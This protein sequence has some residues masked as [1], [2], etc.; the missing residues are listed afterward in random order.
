[1][2]KKIILLFLMLSINCV[3][4]SP[5]ENILLVKDAHVDYNNSVLAPKYT[6]ALD[7]LGLNYTNCTVPDGTDNGPAYDGTGDCDEDIGGMKNYDIVIWFTGK[8]YSD[9]Y[10]TLTDTDRDNLKYFLDNGGKLFL[11]GENIGYDY[12]YH[13]EDG[14]NITAE[15]FFHNYLHSHYCKRT[16][17]LS[18]EG[19]YRDPITTGYTSMTPLNI[20]GGAGVNSDPD[21]VFQNISNYIIDYTGIKKDLRYYIALVK[22][23]SIGSYNSLVYQKFK[24]DKAIVNCLESLGWEDDFS[25]DRDND[26]NWDKDGT[27]WINGLGSVRADTGGPNG[28]KVA[29]FGFGFEGIN[30]SD[31]RI[32]VMNRT[33][34]YLAGPKTEGTKFYARNLD[35]TNWED[36]NITCDPSD[37]YCLREMNP[38]VNATCFNPQLFGNITGAEFFVN[39]TGEGNGTGMNA[40]D[41]FNSSTEIVNGSINVSDLNESTYFVNVHCKDSDNYWGKFDNYSFEVDNTTPST[42]NI[43]LEDGNKYTNKEKP[44]IE[45]SVN[46]SKYQPDFV[47]FSC[48]NQN[49][50]DWISYQQTYS[51]FNITDSNF[52]CNSTDGNRTIYAQ[53]RDIAGNYLDYSSDW[54]ILDRNSS[55]I[56][57]ISPKADWLNSTNVT[58]VFNFTDKFSPEANCS[59]YLDRTL[60]QTNSSVSNNT[61]TNFSASNLSEGSHTW[62]I[63]CEDL[64]GN[65]NSSGRDFSI[66]LSSPNTTDNS[67]VSEPWYGKNQIVEL[68]CSDPNLADG[69]SGSACNS[70]YY[71]IANKSNNCSSFSKGDLVNITC[72]EG[73]IC[74]K[75]ISYYSL[76]KAGNNETVKNS[77]FIRIDKKPP[78]VIINSP[79]SEYVKGD[80]LVNTTITDNQTIDK[81]Y[82]N[83]SNSTWSD[84]SNLSLS[85]SGSY[86][87]GTLDT[88]SISDGEYNLTIYAND[89]F[90]NPNNTE[91]VNITIDNTPPT[92]NATAVKE[93]GTD[94]TFDTWTNSSYVNV[95]L[96]C[97]DNGIGCNITSYCVDTAGTCS[98]NETYTNPIEIGCNKGEVCKNYI[99]YRSNDS[100]GNLEG[101]ET[102]NQIKIDKKAPEILIDSPEENETKSGIISLETTITEDVGV[103]ESWYKIVNRTNKSQVFD[104]GNL[105]GDFDTTWNST[106]DISEREIVTFLVSANDTLGNIRYNVS[107]NFTVD[108]SLPSVVIYYPKKIYLNE[109]FNLNLTAVATSDNNLSFV[110]YNITNSTGDLIKNNTN[111]SVNQVE[112]SFTDLINISN[113]LDGKYNISFY[114]NQTNGNEGTDLNW[115]SVDRVAPNTTDST[116]S[117]WNSTWFKQNKF[118]NLTCLDPNLSDGSC[119][120]SCDKTL[121]CINDSNGSCTPNQNYQNPIE[122]NCSE[123]HTCNKTVFYRSNDTAGNLEN[124]RRSNLILIDKQA[125]NTT[126]NSSS[127]WTNTNQTIKLSCSDEGS[128]C[129]TTL[130]CVDTTKTCSPN[131]SYVNPIEIGCEEGKVC[132]KY[133]NYKSNDSLGNSEKVETSNQI[134]I[135][136]QAP[137]TTDN[138]SSEWTNTNQT[139]KLSCSDE[140][141]GCN[142]TYYCVA[143]KSETCDPTEVYNDTTKVKVGCDEKQVCEKNISYYSLDKAGNNETIRNYSLIRIDKK[144]PEIKDCIINISEDQN[145]ND[146]RIYLGDSVNFSTNVTDL[147]EVSK[148]SVN[149]TNSSTSEIK[150]LDLK[151]GDQTKG[152]WTTSIT[153]T[154]IGLYNITKVFANDSLGNLNETE[155]NLSFKVV[156]PSVELKFGE[157]NEIDAGRN[158]SFNLTFNFKKTVSNQNLTLYIPGYYSNLTSWNCVDCNFSNPN[159]TTGQ[160]ITGLKLNT[161][162]SVGTPDQDLNSTW[163]LEFLGENYSETTK[164]RTPLLNLS[165]FCN[166]NQTCIVNQTEEFNLTIITENI[167]NSNHTGASYDINVSFNCSNLGLVNSSNITELNSTASSNTTWPQ[168]ITKA[169]SFSCDFEV[170]DKDN[171]SKEISKNIKVI[172]TEKPKIIKNYWKED[173]IFNLNET[174]IFFVYVKDNVKIDSVWTEINNTSGFKNHTFT[175]DP[176]EGSYRLDYSNTTNLGN[177]TILR[178]FANDSNNNIANLTVN[179][180]FEV[181]E[182]IVNLTIGEPKIQINES[183]KIYA[184]VSGNASLINKVE[185]SILKPD[186]TTEYIELNFT[187]RTNESYNFVGFYNDITKSGNYSVNLTVFLSSKINK[188][189]QMNFTVPFGNISIE[190]EKEDLY[191][192]V[193]KTYNFTWFII[194]ENGD[195]SNVNAT[196]EI[197]NESIVNITEPKTKDLGNISWK[198]YYDGYKV[199]FNLNTTELENTTTA[200]LTVN[201]TIPNSSDNKTINIT[202][203]SEDN[204]TPIIYGF[205][206]TYTKINLFEPNLIWINATDNNTTIDRVLVEM[207]YPNGEKNNISAIKEIDLYKLPFEANQSGNYSYRIFAI[208]VAGNINSSDYKNFTAFNNYTVTVSPEF[209]KYNREERVYFDVDVRNVNNQ[210]I[211]NFN[212]SLILDKTDGKQTILNKI[213]YYI[214]EDDP[215]PS[216]SYPD[217]YKTYTIYANVTKENNTG[218]AQAEFKVYKLI[219]AEIRYPKEDS[220]FEPGSKVNLEVNISNIRGEQFDTDRASVIAYCEKCKKYYLPLKWNKTTKTYVSHSFTAPNTDKFSISI[221][222]VDTGRNTDLDGAPP[223]VGLTT[224]KTTTEPSEGDGNGGGGNGGVSG[225]TNCTCKEWKDKG[226]GLSNCSAT[227]KYQT[228]TC[229]PSGCS[230]EKQCVYNPVCIPEK[231]F[232]ISIYPEILEIDQGKTKKG[233]IKL[234]NIGEKELSLTISAEKEC[235]DLNYTE[236]LELEKKETKVLPILVHPNLSQG[237]GEYSIKFKVESEGVEKEENLRIVVKENPSISY[238]KSIKKKLPELKDE[239]SEYREA[240]VDVTDLERRTQE[241][242]TLIEN[243]TL[244]IKTDNL[245]NLKKQTDEI[246][247]KVGYID[248]KL[249]TLKIRKFLLENKWSL[250]LLVILTLIF[251]YL[252]TQVI[253]PHFRLSREIRNLEEKKQGLVN[254]RKETEKKYFLRK[255]NEKTFKDILVKTQQT[256][257]EVRGKIRGKRENKEALLKEKL[258]PTALL[259]WII[260]LPVSFFRYSKGLGIKLKNKFG[261]IK[262]KDKFSIKRKKLKIKQIISEP[263]FVNREIRIKGKISFIQKTSEEEFIYKIRDETGDIYIFSNK[264]IKEGENT[265][266]GVLY[267]SMIGQRYVEIKV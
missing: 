175:Y 36:L 204:E 179:K 165:V 148:V 83:L 185:A 4:A 188:T 233:S 221:S 134:K 105:T 220:Y 178:I 93:D 259:I 182:L 135:D 212:L 11:T 21:L 114:A 180:S 145:F 25:F 267:K 254:S 51:N 139:I 95:T 24:K 79:S 27:D 108:N 98:P 198:D 266:T 209:D 161:S 235:C 158:S 260:S 262:L 12:I 264:E 227:E 106:A 194:P 224:T 229:N 64:A 217:N 226:C 151:S 60:N 160:N 153:P 215:S 65:F 19:F 88:I 258:V 104:E 13:W 113:W 76:D 45:F 2:W 49:W 48:D 140:G 216:K 62:N 244:S 52:G 197:E 50:I 10:L 237:A 82:Y 31:D 203:I 43:T 109:N 202:V 33:I 38:K 47:R 171:Y 123:G 263:K 58:F 240:G 56:N 166:N 206:N 246:K 154:G 245:D 131:E 9:D 125:P 122:V 187:N 251:S 156:K 81:A 200:T 119:G 23:W 124:V 73:E 70:T 199:R 252:I 207:T 57:L 193:N 130:Y 132:K 111:S 142:S 16:D 157:N 3:F 183:Q 69:S 231:D 35:N 190:A 167:N 253:Y 177:Y 17:N 127:E 222:A 239:I 74:E 232:R 91:R 86:W 40:T 84:V 173:N 176:S 41:G 92:T 72:E 37:S 68:S 87:L 78:E 94:Y 32:K 213:Y 66:D 101:V 126:D 118:V 89:S 14:S 103:N 120:S 26:D 128:G 61:N 236:T 80:I 205:N 90:R 168:N 15:D 143:N 249:L 152:T 34:N 112:F 115:F 247:L 100:L 243:S 191:L 96:N 59:L 163:N 261:K 257:F 208:D 192:P 42:G 129:D 8:D 174:A 228:R 55:T 210:K 242:E 5:Q 137:N 189:V 53:V 201:S 234:E 147:R 162:I 75:Y 214:S 22:N 71:C 67:S 54:I 172:D 18:L 136:K 146:S 155:P 30:S 99:R 29:Y 184:N 196:L 46:N 195:L 133:I 44:K 150:I 7:S 169:G 144:P 28:Y 110:S 6:Q 159:I 225:T 248:N 219:L 250:I 39:S 255:I 186:S 181:K 77:S 241:I 121:Y 107:R 138:S 211:K 265:I 117:T 238:L 223:Y 85:Q 141:S 1:M 149:I 170:A 164:I 116:N 20:G 97:S 102:S 218:V 256:I 230:A 63:T